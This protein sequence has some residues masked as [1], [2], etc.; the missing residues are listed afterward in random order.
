MNKKQL[1][2]INERLSSNRKEI[3][4]QNIQL[5]KHMV[6]QNELAFCK[7]LEYVRDQADFMKS[8]LGELRNLEKNELSLVMLDAI[9]DVIVQAKRDVTIIRRA[10]EDGKH[11][12][13]RGDNLGDLDLIVF[14]SIELNEKIKNLDNVEKILLAY[15]AK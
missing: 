13:T 8:Y 12:L 9:E 10:Y 14:H 2:Q 3:R 15:P 5:Q 4:L 1:Q 7:M 11:G 6:E